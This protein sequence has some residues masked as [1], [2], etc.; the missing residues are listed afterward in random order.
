MVNAHALGRGGLMRFLICQLQFRDGRTY[1]QTG[2]R[3]SLFVRNVFHCLCLIHFPVSHY[4]DLT[5]LIFLHLVL[6][7]SSQDL[8]DDWNFLKIHQIWVV[9]SLHAVTRIL[10]TTFPSICC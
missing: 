5:T 7:D 4:L 10:L 6:L 1:Q 3:N 8:R 9:I 2:R